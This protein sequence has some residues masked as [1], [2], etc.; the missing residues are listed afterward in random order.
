VLSWHIGQSIVERRQTQGWGA[1]VIDRLILCKAGSRA[2]AEYAL[3]DIAK[4]VGVSSYVT[5]LV[6][7]LPADLRGSLPTVAQLEAELR[8]A[9]GPPAQRGR[10]KKAP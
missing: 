5:R 10:R 2:V 3:R 6:K 4:P 8:A 7:S 9:E 1:A